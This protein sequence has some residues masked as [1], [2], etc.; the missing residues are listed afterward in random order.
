MSKVAL[1]KKISPETESDYIEK[2][3]ILRDTGATPT[4]SLM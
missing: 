4:R 1:R 2:V 3:K